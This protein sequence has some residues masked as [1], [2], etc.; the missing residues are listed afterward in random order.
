MDR[1]GDS[2]QPLISE[3]NPAESPL[4]LA[5]RRKSDNWSAMPPKEADQ[6]TPREIGWVE[7]WIAAGAIWPSVE[8]VQQLQRENAVEWEAEDGVTVSTS[9]GLSVAWNER[10]YAP[11]GLWAWQ[12]VRRPPT[13]STG[14]AAID[15]LLSRRRPETLLLAPRASAETLIRRMFLDLTGLP[16]TPEQ[17]S[18]FCREFAAGPERTLERLVDDLL[19]SPHYGERMAQHWL[20]VVRYADS[21]GFANDYERGSAWRYRDYVVRAFNSDKPF[22][23]FIVEQLAGDEL[24][25]DGADSVAES[26][27]LIATGFLRMGPWELTGMEVELVARQRFLDDVVNSIGETFLGQPLQCARC[28][29]HKFDPIPTRDYYA[30]QAAF[31]TT[32]ICERPAEFLPD[33]NTTGFEERRYL[34]QRAADHEAVLVEIDRILL[35]NS[36]AWFRRESRDPE[37]WNAAVNAIRG[38]AAD[39]RR[40]V[41]DVFAQ[42]RSQL[43]RQRIPQNEF[44]PKLA[45]LTPDQLGLERVA[46]KGLERLK[47]SLERYEPVALSVYSGRTRTLRTVNAPLRIP[48]DRMTAG[49]L[50]QTCILTGGDPFSPADSVTQGALSALPVSSSGTPPA[51]DAISG[52]RLALAHWIAAADNSLTV[53]CIVNRIWMWHFDRPLAANPNNF[54]SSGGRP[55]HPE[56]LDWLA[57]EFVAGGWSVKHLTRLMLNSEA[58]RRSSGSVSD[59]DSRDQRV[60]RERFYAVFRQRRLSAEEL[61]DAQLAASGELNRMLGGIPN[62]PELPSAAALQP[63]QVM[64]TFAEAWTANPLPAQR[65][66][67]SLYALRLRGLTIPAFDVFDAPAA[68]LS[69]ERRN[70]STTAPQIFAL[71]NSQTSFHRAAAMAARV[72]KEF[73]DDEPA[74]IRRCFLLLYGRSP[75]PSELR[76]CMEHWQQMLSRQRELIFP[77]QTV[78]LE[79]LR[80]AVEENTGERFVF[81]ERLHAHADFVPDL[82]PADCD[83]RTRA[84]ADICLVLIN[85]SEFLYV[86]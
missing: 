9:G 52:R 50:Q 39:S 78:P 42:A 64:G 38:G 51:A 48:A 24:V 40:P 33:E 49:E 46:R 28:H 86:D 69:C 53:R 26:E 59:G 41:F 43:L 15:E 67:R 75:E 54:G 35:A 18:A 84:L 63:R 23:E 57:A 58:W 81:R 77:R 12:P 37:R 36:D 25:T 34:E 74:A 8:R 17:I 10:R 85:S 83:A 66:R 82:Q 71:F 5:V 30:I 1:G 61:R 31:A 14:S 4:L 62:R 80:E 72:L 27:R 73:P 29:D 21:S 56:L 19:A 70:V 68:D 76:Y 3:S 2:G 6:L 32:Q 7:E 60:D 20:D 65:H 47:W 22:D 45:G 79:V 16:P 44:P 13:D 11:E 55:E